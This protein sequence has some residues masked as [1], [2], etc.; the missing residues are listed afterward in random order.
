MSGHG[1]LNPLHDVWQVVVRCYLYYLDALRGGLIGRMELF[2]FGFR[3]MIHF[4]FPVVIVLKG[5]IRDGNIL[6]LLREIFEPLHESNHAVQ[7]F[8]G[9]HFNPCFRQQSSKAAAPEKFDE[10]VVV[11]IFFLPVRPDRLIGKP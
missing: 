6:L 5:K 8:L 10:F 3:E 4:L 1:A 7:Y 9:D 2:F 11:I